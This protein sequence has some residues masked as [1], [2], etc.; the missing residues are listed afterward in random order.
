MMPRY[1]YDEDDEELVS[2][3]DDGS[4]AYER[5]QM[6]KEDKEYFMNRPGRD[7]LAPAD[8]LY[9]PVNQYSRE[10]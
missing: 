4:D 9:D 7:G 5:E 2:D 1:N 8:F 6:A 3:F 10:K